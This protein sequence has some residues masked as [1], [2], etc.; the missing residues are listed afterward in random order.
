MSTRVNAVSHLGESV[1]L[2]LANLPDVC[3]RYHR[4][5]HVT[6]HLTSF[7]VNNRV[8]SVFRCSSQSCDELF[9]ANYTRDPGTNQYRLQSTGPVKFEASQFP[10]TVAEISPN[11]VQIHDQ[12]IGAETHGFDQ[13]VGV[14]LRK[15]LEFLIK[16]FVIQQHPSESELIK[17]TQL[18][19]CIEKYVSDT[20]VKDC[21]KRAAWLG[22]DETHY[23]RKWEDQDIQDLKLLV[24]LTSNWVDNVLLTQRYVKK[25]SPPTS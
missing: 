13:L 5:I 11:F 1:P 23:I 25:M 19:S 6:P 3:P 21:A 14:G 9:L 2:I 12:A 8:Q 15:A 4:S 10:E 20:N 7:D 17:K 18:S 16:D 22:N 24:R